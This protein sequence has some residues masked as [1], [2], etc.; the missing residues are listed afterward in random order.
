MLS[1]CGAAQFLTGHGL[2]L[3]H[4]LGVVDPD[5]EIDKFLETFNLPRGNRE[6]IKSLTPPGTPGIMAYSEQ[7]KKHIEQRLLE[8]KPPGMTHEK[9]ASG[10]EAITGPIQNT[11][12][13]DFP[14]TSIQYA[15]TPMHSLKVHAQQGV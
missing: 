13:W 12:H 5:I 9:M 1:S 10:V 15:P 8:E 11:V 3:V 4:G 6:E 2:V 14:Y 7:G